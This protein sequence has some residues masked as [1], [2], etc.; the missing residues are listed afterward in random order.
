MTYVAIRCVLPCTETKETF[1]IIFK[2]KK[3]ILERIKC[4]NKYSNY[5]NVSFLLN[6][7]QDLINDYNSILKQE[8]DFEHSNLRLMDY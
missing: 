7:E 2:K 1:R 5:P 8:E 3:N 4:K 6:L